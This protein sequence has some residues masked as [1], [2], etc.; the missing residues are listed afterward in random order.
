MFSSTAVERIRE[1]DSNARIIAMLRNP[2]ELIP[3]YHS[4][5]LFA[6][7]EDEPDLVR[8]W[9]LQPERAEGNFIPS[10]C[11]D[12]KV[13]QY[14]SLGLLG[15]QV[16]RLVSIFPQEQI[17][18][19]LFD[20]FSTSTA[21]VYKQVLQFLQVPD[22]G[23]HVFPR[24]N[25]NKVHRFSTL[26]GLRRAVARHPSINRLLRGAVERLG[27]A[28]TVTKLTCKPRPAKSL[29]REMRETLHSTF[30]DDIQ[31][32]STLIHRD[33]SHWTTRAKAAA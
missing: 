18:F 17:L 4:Q 10:L 15:E 12:A 6:L 8:A 14:R 32:L 16:E 33:L 25:P 29:A 7:N 19:I 23:R 13:L 2:L 27:I 28:S 5:Q 26:E 24:L 30:A 9:N 22:D 20:D 11:R 21:S 31:L 1:F 3:S